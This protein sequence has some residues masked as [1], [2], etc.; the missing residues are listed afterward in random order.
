MRFDL[1][2]LEGC[3]SFKLADLISPVYIATQEVSCA[4]K[5]EEISN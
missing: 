3:E 5:L 4:R 2:R 1:E